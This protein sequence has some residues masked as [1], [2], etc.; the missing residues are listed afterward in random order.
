MLLPMGA[1]AAF[2][3][4]I[5]TYFIMRSRTYGFHRTADFAERLEEALERN[6][7][8]NYG[9]V[10]K[11]VL[12]KMSQTQ[13]RK[14]RT[15]GTVNVQKLT[16][17]ASRGRMKLED[18]LRQT[19]IK[20]RGDVLSLACGRGGWEQVYAHHPG[21]TS[22][23]AYTLGPTKATGG[24]EAYTDQAFPGK[25]KINL[26]Y[27]DITRLWAGNP[28][29]L[30]EGHKVSLSTP[31]GYNCVLFD[32]GEQRPKC[33][34]EVTKFRKLFMEGVMPAF[35]HRVDAFVLKILTPEDPNILAA[36][37]RIQEKTGRGD[38]VRSSFA[39]PTTRELYFVSTAIHPLEQKARR[40]LLDVVHRVRQDV[41]TRVERVVPSSNPGGYWQEIEDVP[42]LDI[43]PPL[44]LGRSI[45]QL[46]VP[47]NEPT[48]VF[49]HWRSGGVFGFG[50]PGSRSNYR[51]GIAWNL[52]GKLIHVVGGLGLWEFTD[53]TYQGFMKVFH[54]K[55]DTAPVENSIYHSHL[56]E[57]VKG[58]GDYFGK[59]YAHRE[60]TWEETV[61]ACNPKGA[62]GTVD[63]DADMRE[64]LA[65]PD[66]QKIVEEHRRALDEG[67]PISGIFNT[68]GKKE[69]KKNGQNAGSR[70]VA[71]L[72]IPMRVL[73][74]KLMG[75]LLDLTLPNLNR[76]AVGHLGLHDLGMR[77]AEVW[78]GSGC[79][80]DIAGYDT[81]IGVV[82]QSME[83]HLI[84]CLTAKLSTK[85]SIRQMYRLY[86]W[87]SILIP[88]WH[89]LYNRSELLHGRGQVMS[90]RIVTYSM[91]TVLRICI[92]LLQQAT[93]EGVAIENLREWAMRDMEGRS[94]SGGE[95]PWAGVTSGDD[96]HRTAEPSMALKYARTWNVLNN[97]GLV[98][99]DT[100]L[101][102]DTKLVFNLSDVEFCSHTYE[103][104]SY[105]DS[106][107]DRKVFR[108][109]PTRPVSEILGKASLWMSGRADHMM[110]MGWISAQGN[111][112]LLN[113]HHMHDVRRVGLAMKSVVPP[114]VMLVGDGHRIMPKPW[115]RQDQILDII[116]DCL[117]GESTA[118]P[119]Q[120]FRVYSFQHLGYISMQRMRA[121]LPEFSQSALR[122]WRT[123]LYPIVS[124]MAAQNGGDTS[125]L[126]EMR[127]YAVSV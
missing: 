15:L 125:P 89:Q 63:E 68:M 11:D 83:H 108:Y 58:V 59:H 31:E 43:L 127:V 21:V 26:F 53:T 51:S 2:L 62:P 49:S 35:D 81:R 70:M 80:D 55:I 91:N 113:Y 101:D 95:S 45:A 99:K 103:K 38:F 87:P 112:L 7:L 50:K 29:G 92:A 64:F 98:R 106:S 47:L 6:P 23:C 117:F 22:V 20:I 60:L 79:S 54:K 116:N 76:Y 110:E 82:K 85:H 78:K 71:Y 74:Q 30:H 66:A 119:V 107:Q 10:F 114:G 24:H 13:F 86:C 118:Y 88:V 36:L 9:R 84:Q 48:R 34:E 40:L 39:K 97:L 90:G 28:T 33:D 16:T 32:G 37:K 111:N 18:I 4:F 17:D 5:F 46:G 102:A 67:S 3:V 94:L 115:M 44:D 27:A 41:R 126:R 42:G 104:V 52:Y 75:K 120:G 8:S 109:M 56:L 73:E 105:W 77:L 19:G 1:I 100:P 93:A 69:K 124:R 12:N 57:V 65:R 122:D 14:F 61:E 96:C 123:K 121:Y 25:E 72:P